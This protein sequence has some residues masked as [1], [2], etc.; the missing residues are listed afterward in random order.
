MRPKLARRDV[1]D[2][3]AVPDVVEGVEHVGAEHEPVALPRHL[4]VLGDAEVND[5]LRRRGRRCCAR[6]DA[7]A[8]VGDGQ[9]RG[10]PRAAA[11]P[12]RSTGG[13]RRARGWTGRAGRGALSAKLS[14]FRSAAALLVTVKGVPEASCATVASCQPPSAWPSEVAPPVEEGE[15][16]GAVEGEAVRRVEE[17]EAARGRAPSCR[18]GWCRPRRRARSPPRSCRCSC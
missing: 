6:Q 17:R 7:V 2:G 4:E 10:R 5:L 9:R 11:P 18:S 12:A 15:A 3:E 14:K 1:R 13:R 8:E 16:V